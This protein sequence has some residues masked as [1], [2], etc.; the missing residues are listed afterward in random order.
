MR[1]NTTNNSSLSDMMA[2]C[3]LPVIGLDTDGAICMFGN[4]VKGES[5]SQS[6]RSFDHGM[7]TFIKSDKSGHQFAR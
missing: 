6:F 5:E 1:K 4:T 3:R 2:W 7:Y